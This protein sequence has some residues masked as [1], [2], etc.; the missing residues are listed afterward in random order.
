M[1]FDKVMKKVLYVSPHPYLCSTSST[2][3]YNILKQL[4]LRD[5]IYVVCYAIIPEDSTF[6]SDRKITSENIYIFDA[7]KSE[8][9]FE[10]CLK[11]S[12]PDLILINNKL[13]ECVKYF[14]L[15]EFYKCEKISIVN[16]YYEHFNSKL[17]NFLNNTCSEI[18]TH[19]NIQLGYEKKLISKE[20]ACSQLKLDSSF[21]YVLTLTNNNS[22]RKRYDIYIKSVVM[23]FKMHDAE[24]T[25]NV[26]FV[27]ATNINK[28][29]NL[30]E[31]F[32]IECKKHDL[33]LKFTDIF[34]IIQ[35]PHTLDDSLLSL[36]YNIAAIGLNTSDGDGWGLWNLTHMSHGAPQIVPNL[37]CF[38]KFITNENSTCIPSK[39]SYY[40][41]TNE[42]GE[43]H[44]ID[45]KVVAQVLFMYVTDKET[46]DKHSQNAVCETANF[47]WSNAVSEL[48]AE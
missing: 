38:D 1:Y 13:S 25:K 36:F 28:H 45:P 11:M 6:I 43:A 30:L 12:T 32:T 9:N 21:F 16:A 5:D 3:S 42:G 48:V 35:N 33:D 40:V 44:M 34:V 17:V 8:E 46:Y 7:K 23:F 22:S 39:L 15:C 10:Q 26:K 2:I 14:E 18:Y 37:P 27:L 41:C 20:I 19:K 4:S 47:C 24:I 29:F 31:I